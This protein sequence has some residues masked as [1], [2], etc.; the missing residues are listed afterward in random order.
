MKKIISLMLSL[1]LIFSSVTIANAS[2]GTVLKTSENDNFDEVINQI[3]QNK[4]EYIIT[5]KLTNE[6]VSFIVEDVEDSRVVKQLVDNSVVE[7]TIYDK[8][9]NEIEVFDYDEESIDSYNLD[10]VE[11]NEATRS[12]YTSPYPYITYLY[13]SLY[14]QYGYLYGEKSTTYGP[15]KAINISAGTKWSTAISTVLAII[16]PGSTAVGI[17]I[18]LGVSAIGVAI[19]FNVSG[20]IYVRT[21]RWDYEVVSQSQLGL[22]TYQEDIDQKIVDNNTGNDTYIDHEET[23]YSGTRTDMLEEGIYWVHIDNL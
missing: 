21:I 6:T 2:E 10:Q 19:D 9:N 12:S 3:T 8:I 22:R 15:A 20:T 7:E 11:L 1:C 14:S 16:L 13:D 4:Y 5:N 18:A 17:L 23:G